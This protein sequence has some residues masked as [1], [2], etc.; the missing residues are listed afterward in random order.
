[1]ISWKLVYLFRDSLILKI[2]ENPNYL[3]GIINKKEY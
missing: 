1:M 2:I 3:Y